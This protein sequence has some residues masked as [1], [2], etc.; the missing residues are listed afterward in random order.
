MHPGQ[1]PPQ[2]VTVEHLGLVDGQH[3]AKIGVGR[4]RR[5]VPD[6]V[7]Q[8]LPVGAVTDDASPRGQVALALWEPPFASWEGENGAPVRRPVASSRVS[9]HSVSPG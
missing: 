3:D 2:V 5:Q 9:A 8:G 7:G 6:D 4:R 1:Q